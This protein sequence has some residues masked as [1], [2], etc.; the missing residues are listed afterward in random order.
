MIELFAK[1]GPPEATCSATSGTPL[2]NKVFVAK[3]MRAVIVDTHAKKI[4]DRCP[5]SLASCDGTRN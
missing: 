1:G 5:G 2:E 3:R 4:Q